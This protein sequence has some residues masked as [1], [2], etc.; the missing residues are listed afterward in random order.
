MRNRQTQASL[1]RFLLSFAITALAT[2]QNASYALHPNWDAEDLLS[3]PLMSSRSTS[4]S[5]QGTA[6]QDSGPASSFSECRHFFPRGEPPAVQTGGEQRELCYSAF[7]VLHSGQTKTPVFVVERLNRATL[8]QARGLKRTEEFFAEARLPAAERAELADY[9]GSGYSRG[10][11]APAGDMPTTLAMAQSFSLANI[12]PQ[13]PVHNDGAWSDVEHVTRKYVLRA[14]GDVYVFTGPVFDGSAKTIGPG[15]V[16][17][18]SHIFKLVYD[19]T[20]GRSWVHWHANSPDTT[21][22]PPIS[23]KEFTRRTGMHL[24][25]ATQ[26]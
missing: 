16:A 3:P 15:R 13:D 14:Q 8:K 11:M 26:G 6:P 1:K 18:P 17:V 21:M 2:F 12:V 7:A 10:H 9:H 5:D 24:L 22:G 20:T 23:Y 19:S 4:G 25:A